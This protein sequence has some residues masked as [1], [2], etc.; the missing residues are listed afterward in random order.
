MTCRHRDR[1]AGPN[2]TGMPVY[3]VTCKACGKQERVT[4]YSASE[5]RGKVYLDWPD[6]NAGQIT[7]DQNE[8]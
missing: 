8:R 6:W 2:V 1:T 4:A 7:I 5:A 3:T